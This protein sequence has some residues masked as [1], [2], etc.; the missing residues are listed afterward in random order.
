M[1][2]DI[3]ELETEAR[4]LPPRDRAR[5]IRRLIASLDAGDDIDAE[6]QW[7]DE[8]ERRLEAYRRDALTAQ[9]GEEVFD[10]I[11]KRLE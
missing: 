6:E 7:L 4:R 2:E 3:S 1:N 8:A 5:L 11:L 9:P 10:A